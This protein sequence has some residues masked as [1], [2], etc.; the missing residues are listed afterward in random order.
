MSASRAT[1]RRRAPH[2]ATTLL[3]TTMALVAVTGCVPN[4]TTD[5]GT[6]RAPTAP[7]TLNPA[8]SATETG[9][10]T[11]TSAGGLVGDP[12]GWMETSAGTVTVPH[13]M[14]PLLAPYLA[15]TETGATT[16]YAWSAGP[17]AAADVT[18]WVR[19]HN[20]DYTWVTRRTADGLRLI[21]RSSGDPTAGLRYAVTMDV[22]DADP[23][24]D[25]LVR[26]IESSTT[27][28]GAG[29]AAPVAP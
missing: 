17:V 2:H 1:A 18:A 24:G 7:A 20:L 13:P 28:T 8:P 14:R 25:T 22:V 26:L 21:G 11:G 29:T 5:A 3:L 12:A 15:T 19:D 23:T 9:A 10:V 27:G 6:R 16:G 4:P